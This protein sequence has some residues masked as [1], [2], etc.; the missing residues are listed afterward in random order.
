MEAGPG[1][2]EKEMPASYRLLLPG[3]L[4]KRREQLPQ[5]RLMGRLKMHLHSTSVTMDTPVYPEIS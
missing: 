3:Y 1:G 5:V 4:R 2:V